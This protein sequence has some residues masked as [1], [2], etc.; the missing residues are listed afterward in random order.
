M[1]EILSFFNLHYDFQQ[2][3][4][5]TVERDRKESLRGRRK[6]GLQGPTESIFFPM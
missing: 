4:T 2:I 1:L 3:N 6:I 5:D